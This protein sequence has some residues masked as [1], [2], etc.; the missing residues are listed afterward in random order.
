MG[1]TQVFDEAI[2]AVDTVVCHAHYQAW[3]PGMILQLSR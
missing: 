3:R 2:R 1:F